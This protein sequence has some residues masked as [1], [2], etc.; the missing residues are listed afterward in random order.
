MQK[1]EAYTKNF[2]KQTSTS[3]STGKYDVSKLSAVLDKIYST[4]CSIASDV[5]VISATDTI[6]SRIRDLI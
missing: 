4:C 6:K 5:S 3:V 1:K 2:L